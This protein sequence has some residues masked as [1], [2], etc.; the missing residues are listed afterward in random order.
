MPR[1][2]I[3][4]I[5]GAP[6]GGRY[7]SL[8]GYRAIAAVSVVVYHVRNRMLGA[9]GRGRSDVIDNLGNYGVAV[10]FLL[11]GFLLF[12]PVSRRLFEREAQVP[13]ARFL[14]RRFV[15]IFPAYW[16]AC[17]GFAFVTD[18]AHRR[19][20]EPWKSFLL[21]DGGLRFLGVSWTLVIELWFYGLIAALGLVLPWALRRCRHD[22][23][24]LAGQL[25][26]LVVMAVIAQV[27][28]VRVTVDVRTLVTYLN[29]IP[30]Y[31]DWFAWGMLLAV[32]AVWVDRGGRLPS[33][34][35]G[36]AQRTWVCFGLAAFA[37][38]TIMAVSVGAT[39]EASA[40]LRATTLL[41]YTM[42]PIAAFLVLLP[43]VLGRTDTRVQR[44]LRR[45][46][47]AAV[48]TI[49]YGVYLWHLSV[50]AVID[51]Y[52]WMKGSMAWAMFALA[53]VLV[54]SS[55]LAT[56]SYRLIERPALE[57]VPSALDSLADRALRRL[58]PGRVRPAVE[59]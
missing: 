13:V 2:R 25:V 17:V 16:I 12:A 41:R 59:Q 7:A 54:V 53:V 45:P 19:A 37:Y 44:L 24:V 6:H 51:R 52:A 18:D 40:E 22:Q 55:V 8:D 20:V 34:L 57:H 30:S 27:W 43:A 28:R 15:R 21:F 3:E 42:Q 35:H 49:S 58:A 33:S 36:L 39:G 47:V 46:T 11:S 32:L 10:F 50:L 5:V 23:A 48:G 14:L 9:H 56:L 26:L 31:F 38:W 29:W 1:S 4:R